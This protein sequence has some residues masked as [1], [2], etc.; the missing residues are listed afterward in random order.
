MHSTICNT[1]AC[2]SAC[3]RLVQ[4]TRDI[5]C[6]AQ[7]AVKGSQKTSHTEILIV[8]LCGL[9][10]PSSLI[11]T[12]GCFCSPIPQERLGGILAIDELIDVKVSSGSWMETHRQ[13]FRAGER[14]GKRQ[15]SLYGHC[16]AVHQPAE[17]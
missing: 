8:L 9:A 11:V 12:F 16:A 6:R 17:H 14:T 10:W 7:P 1:Q 2:R 3:W 13:P 4:E 15:L 5:D